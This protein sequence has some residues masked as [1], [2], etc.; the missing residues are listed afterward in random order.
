MK[1]ES[2]MEYFVDEQGFLVDQKGFPI[3][4][5]QGKA[6]KLTEENLGYLKQNDLLQWYNELLWYI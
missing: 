3:L 4:D 6:I 2:L 5:D 1:E